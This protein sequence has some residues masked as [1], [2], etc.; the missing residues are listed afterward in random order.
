M[1]MRHHDTN[2]LMECLF[3][4]EWMELIGVCR[5]ELIQANDHTRTSEIQNTIKSSQGKGS[6]TIHSVSKIRE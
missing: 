4:D 6:L 1:R 3:V 2:L 5:W